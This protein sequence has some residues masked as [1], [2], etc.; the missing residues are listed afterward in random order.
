MR[1]FTISAALM[2][3]FVALSA[4]VPAQA[5]YASGGPTHRA[6]GKCFTYSRF[7]VRDGSFGFWGDCA[8]SREFGCTEGG[9]TKF[10]YFG[11]CDDKD[12]GG[13]A[14]AQAATARTTASPRR[15]P[16]TSR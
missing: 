4:S 9:L 13:N 8:K 14:K 1:N 15:R 11:G 12:K 2:T 7:M 3:C 6:D 16:P 10:G 5:E